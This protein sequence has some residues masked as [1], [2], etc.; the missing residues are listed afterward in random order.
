[1]SIYDEEAPSGGGSY[2]TI[3]PGET[4]QMR[5]FGEPIKFEETYQGQTSIRFATLVLF[6]NKQKKIS[7][8]KGYKFGWTIQKALK[9][10]RDDE[11]W[12]DPTGF[13]ISVTRTGAGL[14]TKY[15]VVPKNKGPLGA[16]DKAVVEGC[17]LDLHA[18]FVK[19]NGGHTASAV[20]SDYDPFAP[21]EF[22]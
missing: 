22:E 3:Q 20:P 6:R 8:A 2:L 10:L 1:M 5:F 12:G 17:S 18:L 13:D 16:D 9:A 19:K 4:V 15:A 14:D 7:E 21:E 11:D